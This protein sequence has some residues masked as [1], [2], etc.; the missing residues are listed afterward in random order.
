MPDP[1]PLFVGLDVDKDSI[2]VAHGRG[3]SADHVPA[4]ASGSGHALRRRTAIPCRSRELFRKG[5]GR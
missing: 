4:P 3:Q 1:T 2:T 5:V